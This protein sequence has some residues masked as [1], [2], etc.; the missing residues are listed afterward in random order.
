[1]IGRRNKDS[2]IFKAVRTSKVISA[3]GL[4]NF[5]PDIDIL[6][7]RADNSVVGYELKGL[8]RAGKSM[9]YTRVIPTRRRVSSYKG[10]KPFT[11]YDG[12]DQALSYLV[13]PVS[14]PN[15]EKLASTASI[16]D[17]V[18]LVH[19]EREVF[20]NTIVASFANLVSNCTPIGLIYI[21]HRWWKEVVPPKPNPFLNQELKSLFLQ[22]LN[23]FEQYTKFRL[24]LIQ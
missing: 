18:Y 17:Y 16:F 1:M 6:E 21:S 7:V 24:N 11:F 3:S 15:D 19:P 13:N 4:F 12:L 22:N 20:S 2:R 5:I 9:D 23:A 10:M 8:Q 14:S